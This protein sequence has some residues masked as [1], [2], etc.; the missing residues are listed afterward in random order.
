[1][2]SSDV[3]QPSRT[4][5]VI[6]GP[7]AAGKTSISLEIAGRLGAEIVSMDSRLL[8]RGMDIGTAK[9]SREDRRRIPHHLID[10]ADPDETWSLAQYRQAAEQII[11][12]IQARRILPLLVGGTGQ[13]YRAVVEGWHPPTASRSDVFRARMAE[14]TADHGH[15]ALHHELERIDPTSAARID[16]RNVRRVIRALEIYHL[17]GQTATEQRRKR[18][19]EY[20]ILVLG[21]TLPRPE[22]YER[23][24]AR[25]E[26]MLENGWIEEVR[27]LLQK[28]YS[29]ELPS[30]SAIGY[31]D[32]A[33]YLEGKQNLDQVQ[34]SI[35]QASRKFV[36]RQANWFKPDDEDIEWF[37]GCPGA[38]GL[39]YERIK[40]WLQEIREK[41]RSKP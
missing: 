25:L 9:P 8:Y 14:F 2:G 18:P 13:Y 35:R 23:I 10:V 7:T 15:Q 19:P 31:R 27:E 1:M 40:I 29:P 17:T 37:Q 38:A 12:K 11:G 39:M 36:R 34:A 4:L 32:I 6:V 41:D 26:S 22:L 24:D 16:S 30:F 28:G 5:L 33:R 3:P 20:P 21:V